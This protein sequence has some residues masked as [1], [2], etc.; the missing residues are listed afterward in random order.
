MTFLRPASYF[1]NRFHDKQETAWLAYRTG[2]D[3]VLDWGRRS[4]KCLAKGTQVLTP[5]GPKAIETIQAGDT[6]YSEYGK[7][8]TVRR[9]FDQGLKQVVDLCNNGS[10]IESCTLDHRWLTKA[11]Q[12]GVEKLLKVS[13]INSHRLIQRR[14]VKAPLGSVYEPHAYV[15]GA[16]LGNGCCEVRERKLTIS[17]AFEEVPRKIAS[18]LRTNYFKNTGKNYTWKIGDKSGGLHSDAVSFNH[19]DHWIKGRLSHQK[20]VSVDTIKTWS[21]DSLLAFVAG[22]LDTDGCVV[23]DGKRLSISWCLQSLSVI[24][25][26]QYAILALWQHKVVIHQDHRDKYKNGPVH[27]LSITSNAIAKMALRELDSHVVVPKRKYKSEYDTLK[28]SNYRP[29]A[30]GV[31]IKNKRYERCFDLEVDSHTHLF[32]TATG[33]VTHNSELIS[34][35][36]IEDVETYG[37]DCLYIALTQ[38]Q[39]KE[40]LW[41][42][43]YQRLKDNKNWKPNESRLEWK[44][45][46]SNAVIGLKGADLGKDRLRGN[47]KRVIALDEFA[48]FRDPTIVKDVLVPQL[49]D[50]NGQII[51]CST[52]KGKNHF[53][54]LKNKAVVDRLKFFTS[55]CTVFENPYVSAEGRNKLIQEYTGEDDPLYRQEVLAQYVD[56][57][58]LVFALPQ[59]SYTCDRWDHADLEH[60]FHWRGLDHGFSP[61]PTAC[62]WIAYNRRKGHFLVYSEYKQLALL[63]HKHTEIIN[64]Q[65]PFTFINTFSDVH[66]Q[67]IAEYEDIGLKPISAAEKYDKDSRLLR[68]VNAL[69]MGR[70]KI[71]K[72]CRGLLD[73]MLTYEWNQDGNDHL[74]DAL[75]YG[76]TNLVVPEET[77]TEPQ[78]LTRTLNYEHQFFHQNFGD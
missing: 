6:V 52:P 67:I 37:K 73:E 13:E 43:L 56:F 64:S 38:T 61:D 55:H 28:A 21:R 47:A 44:H 16:M 71:A 48:F 29:D 36:F 35:V 58:G 14:Y 63:I 23:Y 34:E 19:Y 42:K 26:I 69:K 60:S 50:Y 40:I 57:N 33:L 72:N 76:F 59:D 18:I 2:R 49:A 20:L 10:V 53:W 39:A 24:E 75:N 5:T 9:V 68:I 3:L 15:I 17:S 12:S 51:Y 70:L 66:P 46:P 1:L 22:V 4:G 32:L 41:N 25:A 8:I 62:V 74:I 30:V 54:Q 7:P 31:S 78:E 45:L 11:D 77:Y 27:Y 65:E